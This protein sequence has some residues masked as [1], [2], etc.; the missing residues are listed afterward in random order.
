MLV[1]RSRLQIRS[2]M[3][4]SISS[5]R[6]DQWIDMLASGKGSVLVWRSK[7]QIRSVEFRV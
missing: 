4:D 3:F 1:W 7:L 6:L 2:V 5:Y